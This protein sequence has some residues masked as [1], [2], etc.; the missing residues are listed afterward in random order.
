[1]TYI[2]AK[3]FTHVQT[4]PEATWVIPHNLSNSYPIVTTWIEGEGGVVTT[5]LPSAAVGSTDEPTLN[6]TLN[7]PSPTS[8]DLYGLTVSMSGNYAIV[9]AH[10]HAINDR[11]TAFIYDITTGSIVHTLTPPSSISS[12]WFGC[13]VSIRGNFAIVGQMRGYTG[14]KYAGTAYIYNVTTGALVHSFGNPNPDNDDYFGR[15]VSIDGDYAVIGAYEEFGGTGRAYIYST[16]TGGLLYTL[17]NPSTFSKAADQFGKFVCIDGDNIIVTSHQSN[18]NYS[19]YSGSAYVYSASTGSLIHSIHNPDP[20]AHD[21]F[22][23]SVSI[24]GDFAIIGAYRDDT[25]GSNT[26]SAYIYNITTNTLIHSIHNPDT[27]GGY[28]GTS[29]ALRDG[30]A[31]I[32]AT[33]SNPGTGVAEGMV[34]VY[35]AT[36]GV[37]LN[38]ISNPL[39]DHQDLFGSGVAIDGINIIVGASQDDVGDTNAGIAYLFQLAG[40]ANGAVEVNTPNTTTISFT[41]PTI[42]TVSIS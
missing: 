10:K 37:L 19:T 26:G 21:N 31:V 32:G 11:G 18:A 15:G 33:L 38:D 29:V 22:G 14:G 7:N 36:S 16:I 25:A 8:G 5:L 35:D 30:H 42:G 41:T 2:T 23:S 40:P 13:D 4:T 12:G 9:G 17:E 6:Y 3:T 1:M 20:A 27:S 28:F 24:E 39:P 34:H